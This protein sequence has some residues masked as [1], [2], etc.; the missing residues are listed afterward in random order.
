MACK[1]AVKAHDKLKD[2]EVAALLKDLAGCANPFSCPH[3]RPTFLRMSQSE[4]ERDF[5]RK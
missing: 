3:G 1:A 4:I 5:K 2:E